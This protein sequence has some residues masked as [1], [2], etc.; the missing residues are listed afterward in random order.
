MLKNPFRAHFLLHLYFLPF[1]WRKSERRFKS[2]WGKKSNFRLVTSFD[3]QFIDAEVSFFFSL[4]LSLSL[5]L[6]SPFFLFF[7]SF[8][9]QWI[10][11]IQSQCVYTP[12]LSTL[13]I[14]EIEMWNQ[15]L[16]ANYKNYLQLGAPFGW[17]IPI[18]KILH[19]K[20]YK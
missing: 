20:S 19:T 6:F 10:H 9:L 1:C 3:I 18:M 2:F 7:S 17:L 8:P 11:P 15:V 14:I 12:I 16:R 4:S 13:F 5:S